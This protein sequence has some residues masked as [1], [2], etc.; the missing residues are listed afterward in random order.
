MLSGHQAIIR[1]H[2]HVHNAATRPSTGA[3]LLRQLTR[4]PDFAAK[5]LASLLLVGLG[6]LA[7]APVLAPA[8]G[9]PPPRPPAALSLATLSAQRPKS[10]PLP[11]ARADPVAW[12]DARLHDRP[13]L[14]KACTS[15]LCFALG[16][17]VAQAGAPDFDTAGLLFMALWGA[18]PAALLGHCWHAWLDR[19][20]TGPGA[21]PVKIALD[22][23]VFAP[24][25]TLLFLLCRGLAR[26]L[27]LDA[28]RRGTLAALWPTLQANWTVWPF[29]HVATF[30]LVPGAWRVTFLGVCALFW[31]T[32]LS[33]VEV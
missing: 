26:G 13:L 22:Q 9:P 32:F 3:A 20:V 29:V 5:S 6:V 7:M 24:P 18:V 28:A 19:R 33:L 27:S 30:G 8:P 4:R 12:Y 16:H 25:N 10:P 23:L 1:G 15:A 17:L 11:R 14:T 2:P 21:V 31:A